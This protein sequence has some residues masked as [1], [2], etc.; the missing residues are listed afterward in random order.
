MKIQTTQRSISR[1]TSLALLTSVIAVAWVWHVPAIGERAFAAAGDDAV[2]LWN[3]NAGVGGE[4][5]HGGS[6]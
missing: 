5:F 6:F 4:L 3:A 2:T 1:M